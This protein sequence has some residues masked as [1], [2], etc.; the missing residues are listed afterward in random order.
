MMNISGFALSLLRL[1]ELGNCISILFPSKK[2]IREEELDLSQFESEGRE[3]RL[4][5]FKSVHMNT[6]DSLVDIDL[7]NSRTDLKSTM[8]T[9][10]RQ[11]KT[12]FN[13]SNISNDTK[14]P[15]ESETFSIILKNSFLIEYMY[16]IIQG[17][18]KIGSEASNK[19]SPYIL[20]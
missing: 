9:N 14:N 11:S 16:Y 3:I 10:S 15:T 7:N 4:Q 20:K 5:T 18:L 12:A 19:S 2:E 13:I 17:I 1:L 8:L 6:S